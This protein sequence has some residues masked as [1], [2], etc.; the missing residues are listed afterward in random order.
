MAGYDVWLDPYLALPQFAGEIAIE[1]PDIQP[2]QPFTLKLT[3]RNKGLCPW[4]SQ[5]RQRV[6][7]EGI[8]TKLG[9]PEAVTYDGAPIAP[10]ESGTLRV[11]GMA[12]Q[13]TV[14]GTLSVRLCSASR[15]AT[16]IAEASVE[17]A[18]R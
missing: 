3:L 15:L 9:L 13:E 17:V 2:G 12:P 18:S 4:V 6:A 16:T 14:K 11:E 5:A 8:A 10:G 1:I 7:L